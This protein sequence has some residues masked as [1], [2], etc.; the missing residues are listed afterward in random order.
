MYLIGFFHFR[1]CMVKVHM[2]LPYEAMQ[3][4]A[5]FKPEQTLLVDNAPTREA[6]VAMCRALL[7]RM[8]GL[9]DD[10]D[11]PLTKVKEEWR[12]QAAAALG[13]ITSPS[14][15]TSIYM[16]PGISIFYYSSCRPTILACLS[17]H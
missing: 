16:V 12:V 13:H 14:K 1:R 5:S 7:Y 6:R 2:T 15:V 17:D 11:E 10:V 9:D 3:I 4:G 8:H